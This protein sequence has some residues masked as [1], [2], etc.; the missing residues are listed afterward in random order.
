MFRNYVFGRI[1]IQDF[2]TYAVSKLITVPA[3]IGEIGTCLWLLI[4]G[5]QN[6][7]S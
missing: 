6:K 7:K 1:S 4:I 5:V 2:S 3:S